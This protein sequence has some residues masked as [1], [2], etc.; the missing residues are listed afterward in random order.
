MHKE[1]KNK[2]LNRTRI[3]EFLAEIG[4]QDFSYTP[5]NSKGQHHHLKGVHD[6]KPFM[7]NVFENNGG[8]TSLG[9]CSGQNRELFEQLA[10]LIIEHCAYAEEKKLE[11]SLPNFGVGHLEG[12]FGFLG[13]ENVKTVDSKELEY[14]A[15]QARWRG[16]YGDVVTIT[17]YRNGTI[18]FQGKNAHVASLIWDYLYN[19]L[20]L[21]DAIKKQS[22]SYS[23]DVS[24]EEIKDELAA[25]IPVAHQFL[26]ETV[27]KQMSSALMLCKVEIPLEDYGAVSFP[28]LRGLEGFIKQLL[29]KSGL[30]PANSMAIGEYFEQ[31]HRQWKMR[32]IY[33]DYIRGK[34][35]SLISILEDSYMLY[36]NQRHGIFHMDVTVETSRVL[37]SIED[38]KQIVLTIFE[39]IESACKKL[40]K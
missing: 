31:I 40:F 30:K 13:S 27:R 5:A 3:P 1:Y 29:V 10:D 19:V 22:K 33:S 17:T 25:K 24:V 26:E 35:P 32:A 9:F 15:T 12:F 34:E 14:G 38:A 28:A 18:Q 8:T 20:S 4:V 6:G 39:T 11:L 2:N 23:I 16:P 7:L 37:G 36:H 21:E